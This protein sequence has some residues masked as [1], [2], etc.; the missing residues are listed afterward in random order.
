MLN[1]S[2]GA[3]G[4]GVSDQRTDPNQLLWR[5]NPIHPDYITVLIKREEVILGNLGSL[6]GESDS[7]NGPWMMAR[8]FAEK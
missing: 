8:L 4:G 3:L 2:P 6:F 1:L 5:G 7:P